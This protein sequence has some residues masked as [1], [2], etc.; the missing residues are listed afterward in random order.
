MKLRIKDNALRIR[1]T[2]SEVGQLAKTGMVRA[3]TPFSNATFHYSVIA[4]V[5]DNP[6]EARI[7]PYRMEMLVRQDLVKNWPDNNEVGFK[8]ST[9]LPDGTEL[10]LVLEKDFVCLDDSEEDQSDNYANPN[11]VCI[12]SGVTNQSDTIINKQGK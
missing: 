10:K 11:A 5:Q 6:L 4:T 8:A 3:S 2:R 7:E 1:L 12:P 9:A